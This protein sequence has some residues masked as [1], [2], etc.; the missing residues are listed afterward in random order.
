MTENWWVVVITIATA[1]N[2]MKA[3]G[4]ESE[5]VHA[6][7]RTVFPFHQGSPSAWTGHTEG[8]AGLWLLV[9]APSLFQ[10]A[11]G[12]RLTS[13]LSAPGSSSVT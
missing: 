5:H 1:G 10:L 4:C 6:C 7:E 8:E 11:D 2:M 9:L 12:G 3:E 13:P